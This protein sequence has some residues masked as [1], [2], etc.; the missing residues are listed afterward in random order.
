[1]RYILVFL[2]Y[3]NQLVSRT[4]VCGIKYRWFST[5]CCNLNWSLYDDVY[6]YLINANF[7]FRLSNSR[8]QDIASTVVLSPDARFT[9][10][11]SDGG[12]LFNRACIKHR[13]KIYRYSCN[14]FETQRD[15]K[16]PRTFTFPLTETWHRIMVEVRESCFLLSFQK[17]I[18][19]VI[20]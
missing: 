10:N 11:Y 18:R 17:L 2:N 14:L 8:N 7:Y 5:F 1:M 9:R 12:A 4:D 13:R 3:N 6:Y 20:D 16:I 15:N 19:D